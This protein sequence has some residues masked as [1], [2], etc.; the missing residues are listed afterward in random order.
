MAISVNCPSCNKKVTWGDDF[1]FK[2]FCCERCKL[3]DLGDWAAEK[4]TIAGE[5][6]YLPED[7]SSFD[8]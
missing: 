8:D 1:P 4:H 2:P 3:I 6:A 7:L 5:P